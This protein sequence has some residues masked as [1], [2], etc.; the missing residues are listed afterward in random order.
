MNW[1][2]LVVGSFVCGSGLRLL[3]I[4]NGVWWAVSGPSRSTRLCG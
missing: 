4:R 2:G 3:Q 1:I